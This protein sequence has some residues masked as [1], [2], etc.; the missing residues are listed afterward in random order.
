LERGL[1]C[2]NTERPGFGESSRL[3][4]RRFREHADD[5]AAI[6]DVAG[7]ERAYIIGVSGG[8]PHVLAFAAFHPDRVIAAT[9]VSGA[10]PLEAEEEG[11]LIEVNAR[12]RRLVRAGDT[13]GL[14]DMYNA[15]RQTLLSDPF[16]A[17]QAMMPDVP[18]EDHAAMRTQAW[19]QMMAQAV[20]E[21]LKHGAEG[22]VD[23][24]IALATPLDFEPAD[25]ATSVTWWHSA[26]DRNAPLTAA[27]RLV[28]QLPNARLAS[29]PK[30]HIAL[31]QDPAIL[32]ELL[33]R[34][35][36]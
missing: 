5:V 12:S 31:G 32:D 34:W 28:E 8:G 11:H 7:I 1:R 26:Q 6:L 14:M 4:G 30:G 29:L 24:G 16:G 25:V 15:M 10:A 18:E 17:F 23:E 36:A 2:I 22:W 3:P 9:I 35:A 13:A 20:V 21:A 33:D 27:Q 19:Q